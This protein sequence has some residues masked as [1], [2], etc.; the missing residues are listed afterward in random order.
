MKIE[1]KSAS[2][3]TLAVTIRALHVNGKQMTLAVFRQLPL[4]GL[5]MP[6]GERD[7][8]LNWWGLVHYVLPGDEG[9]IDRWM[10]VERGGVLFRAAV[11]NPYF[12][13]ERLDACANQLRRDLSHAKQ[14]GLTGQVGNYEA[15]IETMRKAID[16]AK[17]TAHVYQDAMNMDQLFIAV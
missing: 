5:T 11:T 1:T 13:M 7:G 16:R 9:P 4:V 15:R 8:S 14:I 2:L 12:L 10:V 17:K 3:S 6:S